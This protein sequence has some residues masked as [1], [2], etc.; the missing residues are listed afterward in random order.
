MYIILQN[1]TMTLYWNLYIGS[2][3]FICG[4]LLQVFFIFRPHISLI[5]PFVGATMLA[6]CAVVDS[7]ITLFLGQILLLPIWWLYKKR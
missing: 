4:I 3:F 6:I 1:M 7:D 5:F 2:L